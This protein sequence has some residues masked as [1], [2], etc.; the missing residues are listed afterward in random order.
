MTLRI[1]SCSVFF[2]RSGRRCRGMEPWP[3]SRR[4]KVTMPID[5]QVSRTSERQIMGMRL[6]Y[7]NRLA[8]EIQHVHLR[9]TTGYSCFPKTLREE[10]GLAWGFHLAGVFVT[11]PTYRQTDIAQRRWQLVRLR[12]TADTHRPDP[13]NKVFSL[14]KVQSSPVHS[15]G[16]ASWFGQ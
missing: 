14:A 8:H 9:S 2:C 12:R 11:C 16:R 5:S 7:T 10:P 6:E 13:K 3:P 15:M 4:P 1:C